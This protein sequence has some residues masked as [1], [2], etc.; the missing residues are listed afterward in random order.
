MDFIYVML[1]GSVVFFS[2]HLKSND[3]QFKPY[4]YAVSTLFGL[5]MACVFG[6]L[7]VDVIRGLIN[8]DTFLIQN[9][10]VIENI[11]GGINIINIMRWILVGSLTIYIIPISLYS[12]LFQGTGIVCEILIGSLSFLFYTPTYLNILNI[13]SLCRIDDISWGTKGLD[14]TS[15]KNSNLKESW[16]M[17]K[18][19][20]ISKYVIWNVILSTCLLTLGSSFIPRFFVTFVIV[21]LIGVTMSVKVIV[22]VFYM[23][24]YW[25]RT[26]SFSKK[27]PVLRTD[28][29][30][31]K[32]IESYQPE[33]M[34]EVRDNLNNIK[35]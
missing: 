9:K 34:Q 20:H 6:V 26:A 2:L 17:I 10:S 15:S 14:S 33:I 13:Y 35:E 32:L 8:N 31:D 28:S 29:R 1:I 22:G 19:I 12:L 7:I 30:I 25:C 11:P 21:I 18:F 16:K 3:K 24:I 27:T 23:I 4:I 5:F